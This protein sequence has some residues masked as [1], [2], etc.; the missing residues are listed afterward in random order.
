MIKLQ[1]SPLDTQN[2]DE[3]LVLGLQTIHMHHLLAHDSQI[4]DEKK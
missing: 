1:M 2:Y 3:W 4:N